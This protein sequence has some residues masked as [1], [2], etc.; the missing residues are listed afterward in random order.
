MRN[1]LTKFLALFLLVALAVPAQSQTT[2][3]DR[4]TGSVVAT[5]GKQPVIV[6]TT[7][8]ITL[9]GVQ[10]IDGVTV[11]DHKTA[12]TGQASDR[13]LV[14]NQSDQTANGIYVVNNSGA[15]TRAQDFTGPSGIVKGQIVLVTSG[16]LGKGLWQLTTADPVVISQ[17][18]GVSA[19]PSNITFAAL[20]TNTISGNTSITGTLAVSGATTLSSTLGVTGAATLSSTLGVTGNTTV[21]GTLGVTGA[22]TLTTVTTGT[23]TLGNGSTATTQTLGDSTTK[24]STD[25]FVANAIAA[26]V[27]PTS[28][29]VGSSINARMTL[30][31]ASATATFA[32]DEIVVGTA[33][34]GTKTTLASFSQAVN[35]ASTGIGGMDTGTVPANG[36]VSIYAAWNGTSKGAFACNA[37]TSTTT[38]YSGANAPSGYTQTALIGTFRTSS[39]QLIAQYMRGRKV[40]FATTNAVNTGSPTSFTSLSI[41]GIVPTNAMTVSGNFGGNAQS[42]NVA[43]AIA[44]DANGLGEQVMVCTQAGGVIDSFQ[45]CAAPF[46]DLV[47]PTSQTM[48]W[49]QNNGSSNNHRIDVNAYTF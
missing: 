24:V 17:T 49:K 9:S 3:T 27:Q 16:T 33:L 12:S 43:V 39:S 45:P 18:G 26:I 2:Y 19:S 36:F 14:K 20:V 23:A 5:I 10:T 1:T 30:A 35:L 38:V 34:G 44:S 25:Q 4:T 11:D 46:T 15:W 6:A 21:G 7:A 42:N 41:S 37:T 29:P 28:P 40:W 47:I 48:Y 32:A 8:N 13:V 22:T 31:S